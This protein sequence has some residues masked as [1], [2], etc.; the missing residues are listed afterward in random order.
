MKIHIL[1]FLNFALL[2]FVSAETVYKTRN[3]EG[4][5]LFSDVQS[6][7]AEEIEIKEVQTLNIPEAKAFDNRPTTKLS[8]E[9]TTYSRL[10]ITSPE[11]EIT[12]HSNE[13]NVNISVEMTPELAE[14]HVL[15]LLIDGKEVSSG[16][17]L[18]FSIT[19]LDRGT[20]AVTSVVKNEKNKVLKQSE[21]RVFHLRKNSKLFK[22]RT[23]EGTPDGAGTVSASPVDAAVPAT[24][25]SPSL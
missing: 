9:E 17:S 2:T 20:H 6:E 21:K 5:I 7:G 16:K 1:L 4:N 22:N 10:E 3:A 25:E 19:G 12:I 24:P 15:A 11:N 8:P 13:G 18:Q 23:G 14:K